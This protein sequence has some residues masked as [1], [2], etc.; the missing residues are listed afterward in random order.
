[1]NVKRLNSPA[2]IIQAGMYD[3]GSETQ[4]GPH[5]HSQPFYPMYQAVYQT[6]KSYESNYKSF[7]YMFAIIC[8]IRVEWIFIEYLKLSLICLWLREKIPWILWM[9]NFEWKIRTQETLSISPTLQ[10]RVQHVLPIWS[11]RALLCSVLQSRKSCDFFNGSFCPF[12][13]TQK[14]IHM[15]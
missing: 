4:I 6:N 3:S 7:Q 2:R 10:I 9:K 11:C 15:K 12:Q 1:M 8:V 5:I 14:K 13:H